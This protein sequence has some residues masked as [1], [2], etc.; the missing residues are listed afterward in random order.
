MQNFLNS[1]PNLGPLGH[2]WFNWFVG[3]CDAEGNFQVYPKKRTLKSGEISKY[4]VGYAFHLSL[5]SRELELIKTI[6][7]NLNEIGTINISPSKP[8]VRLAINDRASLLVICRIFDN[9]R[10]RTGHQLSR[11]L[12]LKEGLENNIKEFKTLELYNNYKTERM[13][14]ISEQLKSEVKSDNKLAD[15][16]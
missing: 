11:Y 12:F 13:L 8:D 10:L 7:K 16:V 6:Y 4:N 3:F 1:F 2:K 5:H 9:Y 15:F 14:A